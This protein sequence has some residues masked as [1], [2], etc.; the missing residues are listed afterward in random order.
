MAATED[1]FEGE[2]RVVYSLRALVRYFVRLGAL[3]FGGPVAL[4]GFMHRELVEERRWISEAEYKDGLT[5]AQL[6]PGPLAAQLCF[7][8]G[9]VH[10]GVLGATAAG[11]AFVI[12]GFAIVVAAGWLYVTYEGTSWLQDVSTRSARPSSASSP[13][14]PT[15]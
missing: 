14:A 13:P 12:P 7:Y 4:T 10:H 9:F 5:L 6:A 2:A 8:L 11:I 3:G 15:S 1:E